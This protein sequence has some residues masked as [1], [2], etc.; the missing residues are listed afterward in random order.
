MQESELENICELCQ[1]RFKCWQKRIFSRA[2]CDGFMHLS[3]E[4]Y[5]ERDLFGRFFLYFY[6]P[7]CRSSN[8]RYCTLLFGGKEINDPMK[9]YCLDCGTSWCCECGHIFTEGEGDSECPHREICRNCMLENG[10]LSWLDF[11]S[12]FCV[13]CESFSDGGG[14]RLENPL[15]CAYKLE[16]RCPYDDQFDIR[17]CPTIGIT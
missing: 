17:E 12:L 3:P 7:V 14:C 4:E 8:R 9:L 1:E 15:E 6:C 10:Y 5:I 2:E 13:N 16:C 11:Y